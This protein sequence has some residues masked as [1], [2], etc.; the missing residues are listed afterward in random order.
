MSE[1][2][3]KRME[4]WEAKANEVKNKQELSPFGYPK[5]AD[6]YFNCASIA[7][8]AGMENRRKRYL[9]MAFH[10]LNQ[11]NR[12]HD[13]LLTAQKLGLRKI[14]RAY[15]KIINAINALETTPIE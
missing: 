12:Y 7:E 3:E 6:Y 4:Y 11:H 1:K 2:V 8:N 14:K 5:A 9:Y 15:I 10:I 13:A